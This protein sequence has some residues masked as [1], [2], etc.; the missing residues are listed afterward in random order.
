[1]L[2]ERGV[3]HS[4]AVAVSFA[5][6]VGKCVSPVRASIPTSP[7]R[8]LN[9]A[10]TERRRVALTALAWLRVPRRPGPDKDVLFLRFD[11]AEPLMHLL[12]AK[13]RP[14]NESIV[15]WFLVE[16]KLGY[17]VLVNLDVDEALEAPSGLLAKQPE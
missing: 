14:G 12:R 16:H 11:A 7:V 5:A 3:R 15:G 6:N 2:H 13:G 10:W 1:M 8:L 4:Y 9:M 17:V